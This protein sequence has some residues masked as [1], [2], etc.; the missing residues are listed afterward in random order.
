MSNA[1][2]TRKKSRERF[3]LDQFLRFA[4]IHPSR[5]DAQES[6][7]FVVTLGSRPT[8]IELVSLYI[9]PD[10]G[11]TS[12]Q[13]HE[14]YGTRLVSGAREMYLK[15]GGRPCLAH[16]LFSFGADFAKCNRDEAERLLAEFIVEKA[17]RNGERQ[18]F[19]WET[20]EGRVP[21]IVNCVQVLGVP[22]HKYGRWDVSRAGWV[23]PLT[24]ELVER[25]ICLKEKKL[26]TYRAEVEEVW[27][28]LVI[29]RLFPSQMLE[30]GRDFPA[31]K[32]E[33]PFDR[34]FLLSST[35]N[36]LLEVGERSVDVS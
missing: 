8:G 32:I 28:L 14:S 3:Y 2:A 7:D 34:T 5:I 27:L 36:Q 18:R 25:R 17:P 29:D 15:L 13:A 21:E 20:L 11:R 24:R 26:E 10:G 35:E 22:D 23:A 1:G 33:S 31:G 4:G 19:D 9:R 6:P 16:I 12:L 30:I